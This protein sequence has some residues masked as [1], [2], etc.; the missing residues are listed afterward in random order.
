MSLRC[1]AGAKVALKRTQGIRVDV[2][3]KLPP[4]VALFQTQHATWFHEFYRDNHV[5]SSSMATRYS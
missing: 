2:T 5:V 1:G 4:G 3:G